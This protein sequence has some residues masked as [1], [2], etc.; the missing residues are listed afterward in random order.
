[1]ELVDTL[2]L[3][4]SAKA[5]GFESLIGHHICQRRFANSTDTTR[6][7]ESPLWQ[8]SIPWLDSIYGP[9]RLSVRTSG[10]QPEKRGSIPLRDTK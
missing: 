8:G 10:F 1:M 4:P 2:G 3:G 9:V 6:R 7:H 5:W